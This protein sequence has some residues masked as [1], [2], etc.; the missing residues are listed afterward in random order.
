[1]Q[2]EHGTKKQHMCKD[3]GKAFYFKWRLS[4]HMKMHTSESKDN[5]RKCHFFNNQ[6]QCPFELIGCKFRHEESVKCIFKDQ[7]KFD[8]CQFRH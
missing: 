2:D 6:K 1:M 3:C 5:I 8:K 7:C 4:M